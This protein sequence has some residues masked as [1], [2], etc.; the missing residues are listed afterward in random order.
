MYLCCLK[1]KFCDEINI[2]AL[3]SLRLLSRRLKWPRGTLADLWSFTEVIFRRQMV[4]PPP[5][6]LSQGCPSIPSHKRTRGQRDPSDHL[7]LVSTTMG[8]VPPKCAEG[9]WPLYWPTPPHRT[10]T[11]THTLPDE[12][13]AGQ[14][15]PQTC[16]L[17]QRLHVRVVYCLKAAPGWTVPS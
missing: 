17:R 13:P 8:S 6:G 15:L 16:V 12:P 1:E 7:P 5:P 14:M 4:T 9:G 11:H 10:H 3:A 2:P